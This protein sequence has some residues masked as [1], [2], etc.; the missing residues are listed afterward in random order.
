MLAPR[1]PRQLRE[2]LGE[3]QKVVEVPRLSKPNPPMRQN[4][5]ARRLKI[6]VQDH[7]LTIEVVLLRCETPSQDDDALELA[8]ITRVLVRLYHVARFIVNAN[9]GIMRTAEKLCVANGVA[10]CV[11]L[12]IPQATEDEQVYIQTLISQDARQGS[13][14]R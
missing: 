13:G 14:S 4:I 7:P 2:S 8:E 11:R 6:L 10:D 5:H 9:H 1:H 3:T 12:R